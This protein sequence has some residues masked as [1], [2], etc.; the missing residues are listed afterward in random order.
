MTDTIANVGPKEVLME[1]WL[2]NQAVSEVVTAGRRLIDFLRD[3]L[4][5]I[6]TKEGCGEG[7]CGSCTVF[8]NGT[9]VLACLIP[10]EKAIGAQVVTIEGIGTR[11]SLHPVQQALI[12]E[13]GVQCGMCTPGMVMAGVDLL[14]RNPD[15]NREEIIEGIAGNLCRC[16]GY[17]KI[18]AAVQRA[19]Q[20]TT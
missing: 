20:E 12:E 14:Q 10:M 19:A 18:I 8:L 1:L 13:A 17:Q 2:N 6:G 7:E 11:T 4:H 16:T 5:L 3:A 15:P 9:A